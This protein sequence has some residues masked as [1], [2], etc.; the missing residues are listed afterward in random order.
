MIAQ[1]LVRML[2]MERLGW[3][4]LIVGLLVGVG[5]WFTV[6]LVLLVPIAISLARVAKVRLLVPA[7]S[8]LAGL[9]A[10][11]GLAPPHPGPLAAIALLQADTGRTILWSLVV[12][13][14]S[15]AIAGPLFWRWFGGGIEL[16]TYDVPVD[17]ARLL[18]QDTRQQTHAR[19]GC[20]HR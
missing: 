6:G 13:T 17:D 16:P 9:S 8:M 15:A 18:T 11:H 12:G 5:V 14:I 1:S 3:T 20:C 10:M 19:W 2:G 7:M 4:M